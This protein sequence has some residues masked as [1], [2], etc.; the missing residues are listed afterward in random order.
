MGKPL[1]LGTRPEVDPLEETSK[2]SFSVTSNTEIKWNNRKQR[3]PLALPLFLAAISIAFGFYNPLLLLISGISIL[4]WIL[5]IPSL[6]RGFESR[7]LGASPWKHVKLT[8]TSCS[9]SEDGKHVQCKTPT[10]P[11]SLVNMTLAD[12]RSILLGDVSSFVRAVDDADGFCLTVTLRPAKIQ[13]ALDQE[14]VTD[15]IEEYLNFITK[16]EVDAYILYRGGLWVTH[17]NA[18]GHVKD[19]AGVDN[20]DSAVRASIP[21][22]KWKRAKPRNL[23]SSSV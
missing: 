3:K 16:G 8:D 6:Q 14:R 22:E 5:L 21:M 15:R 4:V 1:I 11:R 20:F 18:V 7:S 12:A 2:T 19:E 17:V 13:E 23:R 10:G 9:I